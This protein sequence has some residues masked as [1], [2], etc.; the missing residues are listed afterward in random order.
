MTD[1]R[2]RWRQLK[3]YMSCCIQSK[4]PHFKA[5]IIET[6]SPIKRQCYA[7]VPSLFVH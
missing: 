3:Q 6:H 7:F 4:F 5:K 2:S 1:V